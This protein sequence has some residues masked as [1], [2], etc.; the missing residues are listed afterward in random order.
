M[1]IGLVCPYDLSK[2]GGV[3]AQVMGL[4]S[5]L[6]LLGEDVSI[7]GPGL[8]T[9]V[10]GVDLLLE[11]EDGVE[12]AG[13]R[14][15]RFRIAFQRATVALVEGGNSL[16]VGPCGGHKWSWSRRVVGGSV[17]SARLSRRH[18]AALVGTQ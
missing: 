3:Q 7:V 14:S 17:G 6:R 16:V 9:G 10:E 5:A 15:D 12:I 11:V 13:R 2:P 1:R 18:G 4:A 8:P